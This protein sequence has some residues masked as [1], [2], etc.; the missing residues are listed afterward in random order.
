MLCIKC[1]MIK[2][3]LLFHYC[4]QFIILLTWCQIAKILR[5]LKS[6]ES[7]NRNFN[8]LTYNRSIRKLNL[9]KC[10]GICLVL[11]IPILK[12]LNFASTIYEIGL[13][14]PSQ[15]MQF[16]KKNH[17]P[18]HHQ[19]FKK[20]IYSCVCLQ[21]DGISKLYNIMILAPWFI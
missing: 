14:S 19:P 3:C 15:K 16:Q 2:Y 20:E 4:H 10:I 18:H 12:Q 8:K 17:L 7:R 13:F 9:S 5:L 6:Y 21:N 1:I 11:P